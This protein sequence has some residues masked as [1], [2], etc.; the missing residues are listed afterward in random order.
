MKEIS[1]DYA[2]NM[3]A[4]FRS[5]C[6]QYDGGITATVASNISSRPALLRV[7]L[8]HL[9]LAE[10]EIPAKPE[11]WRPGAEAKISF[12]LGYY[13]SGAVEKISE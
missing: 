2:Y 7:Y 6:A 12:W 8:R 5:I 10:V 13:Q 3:G 1:S 4:V 9:D 11:A